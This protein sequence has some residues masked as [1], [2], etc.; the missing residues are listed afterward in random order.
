LDWAVSISSRVARRE[1]LA[2]AVAER[3]LADAMSL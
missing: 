3:H 1:R 2:E